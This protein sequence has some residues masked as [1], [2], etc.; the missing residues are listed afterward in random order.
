MA[1]GGFLVATGFG[2]T[3]G[4]GLIAEGAGDLF[5]AYRAYSTRQFS[6]SDYMKQKAI[7]IVISVA[8]AGLQT[9]V[10]GVKNAGKGIKNVLVG[11]GE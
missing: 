4:I 2:S 6:W 5:T 8:T 3:L 7:S 1:V 10:T 9:A 11:V